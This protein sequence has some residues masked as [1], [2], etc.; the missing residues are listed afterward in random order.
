MGVNQIH[1][2]IQCLFKFMLSSQKKSINF[3]IIGWQNCKFFNY[4]S[5]ILIINFH[6][7]QSAKIHQH[8]CFFFLIF[9]CEILTCNISSSIIK[10]L[11]GAMICR[12]LNFGTHQIGS[13]NS[14]GQGGVPLFSFAQ[15]VVPVRFV[16]IAEQLLG[17]L[18]ATAKARN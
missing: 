7:L 1:L 6:R 3:P 18:V 5:L 15:A 10:F 4:E 8:S 13:K 17:A 12:K 14:D 11:R 9:R 16:T 2:H